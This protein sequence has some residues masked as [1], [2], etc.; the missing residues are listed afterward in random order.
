MTSALGLTLTFR[1]WSGANNSVPHPPLAAGQN[2]AAG[3]SPNPAKER[4]PLFRFSERWSGTGPSSHPKFFWGGDGGAAYSPWARDDLRGRAVQHKHP[5]LKL[6]LVWL[7]LWLWLV[8][9]LLTLL[10]WL[11]YLQQGINGAHLFFGEPQFCDSALKV[12]H[13]GC[14]KISRYSYR[15]D[16]DELLS[17]AVAP[18]SKSSGIVSSLQPDRL[19]RGRSS[20]SLNGND[21]ESAA[22]I[23]VVFILVFTDC[24]HKGW[25][26]K[27]NGGDE[28]A[29]T[30][31]LQIVRFAVDMLFGDDDNEYEENISFHE[32]VWGFAE[33]TVSNFTD[34][35]FQVHFRLNPSTFDN[36]LE[37]MH[38]IDERNFQKI[39]GNPE[40]PL[41]K[42]LMIT[43][44]YLANN[45][46]SFRGI[47][48]RFGIS[49]STAWL[50][51]YKICIKLLVVN[52]SY[53]IISFPN[54]N[55]CNFLI[56]QMREKTGVVGAIDGSHIPIIAP[57][58]NAAS[59]VNRKGFH[60]VLL[61]A[62][63]DSKKRFIDCYSGEAGSIHDACLFRRSELG[64][65][66]LG[67]NIPQ[68]GHLLGDS[69]YPL[70]NRLM[71]PFRDNGHLNDIQRN[72][73]TIH[74][75]IRVVIEQAFAL[76]KGRFRRLKLLETRRLDH[77]PLIILA[78]CILHNICLE[79]DDIPNDINFN[80]EMA[81]ERIM[82]VPNI[83]EEAP[84][85]RGNPI[86]KRNDIANGFHLNASES[87]APSAG[88]SKNSIVWIM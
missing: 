20:G 36:L 40:V 30:T 34:R 13:S 44:W 84:G 23:L 81:E 79:N 87:L 5:F 42:Q 4:N 69:A 16:P 52:I 35:Q 53:S 73:N 88:S 62:T 47:A 80:A 51:V 27:L 83:H 64:N 85:N 22:T 77:I 76:L 38:H 46:E 19:E 86:A 32:K 21:V 1:E 3:E 71:V 63:C 8:L 2:P 25:G 7:L 67:L 61:Q 55:K 68:D 41:S 45:I 17:P 57:T 12:V 26:E 29:M 31:Q 66:L 6:L 37:K 28:L 11:H 49:I 43:L 70:L 78:C 65:N 9:R 39:G 58:E 14:K 59:Y 15:Q 50:S 56:N 33:Q 24:T 82:N 75:K 60:S 54:E 74:S 48:N 18:S 72:Y 10:M